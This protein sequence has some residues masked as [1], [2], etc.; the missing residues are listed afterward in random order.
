MARKKTVKQKRKCPLDG[1]TYEGHCTTGMAVLTVST[2][3]CNH[4]QECTTLK[5]TLDKK[6]EYENTRNSQLDK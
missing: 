4:E 5:Q 2:G 6:L 3:R 1:T